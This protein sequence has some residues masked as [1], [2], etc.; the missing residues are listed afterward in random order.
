MGRIIFLNLGFFMVL[1]IVTF[2]SLLVMGT[3]PGMGHLPGDII[4]KI[5]TN[6]ASSDWT[7]AQK[8]FGLQSMALVSHHW[9]NAMGGL[10]AADFPYLPE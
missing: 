7:D 6:V 2:T 4:R 1:R 9:N 10:N 5:A 8:A 3:L